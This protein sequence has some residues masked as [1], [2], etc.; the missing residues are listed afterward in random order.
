M[1]LSMYIGCEFAPGQRTGF[2]FDVDLTANE[3]RELAR[4]FLNNEDAYKDFE[5]IKKMHEPLYH[6]IS[7]YGMEVLDEEMGEDTIKTEIK[8]AWGDDAEEF[9]TNNFR[10]EKIH[11]DFPLYHLKEMEF[12]NLLQS[13]GREGVERV[14]SGLRKIGFFKAPA[15]AKKHLAFEGG[16]VEH[17][18]T[19]YRV[20]L[21]LVEDMRIL[22]PDVTINEDSL[23]IVALL[24]D[25]CKATRYRW[26]AE[27]KEYE[28]D[29]SV[30][31]VGHG[32]KSVIMLL[33]MGLELYDDEI[34]AIRWHM[35]AW[36]LSLHSYE[37]QKNFVEA[38]S[39]SPLVP[40]LQTADTLAALIVEKGK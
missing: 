25:I 34:M 5:A 32:E 12:C 35:G 20:L 14:L 3:M 31:P 39:Q 16:L 27:K 29:Y 6:K 2:D 30:M 19:V 22:R 38:G 9:F 28:S 1:K 4:E 7:I 33:R 17:S 37:A 21:Q 11:A 10:D 18:L 36:D 40:L 8:I 13:T 24:H 26:N 15:A 23:K